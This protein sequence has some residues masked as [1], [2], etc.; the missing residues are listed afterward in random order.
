M[1]DLPKEVENKIAEL[2]MLEQNLQSFL[3]QRQNFQS[4]LVEVESAL[5]ELDATTAA[6]KIVGNIMVA[7][8]KET[9]KSDLHQ[10]KEML[11]LRLKTI[12]KQ[13]TKLKEKAT[14]MQ[15][16]VMEEMKKR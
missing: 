12:E 6:Y 4:Q 16:E 8:N 3:L 1:A 7:A 11:A 5:S 14:K 2:Q 15:G 9:L 13:E 10:K